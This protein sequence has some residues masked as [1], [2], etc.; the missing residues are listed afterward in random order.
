MVLTDQGKDDLDEDEHDHQHFEERGPGGLGLVEHRPRSALRR[1]LLHRSSP[2][3][4]ST[5]NENMPTLS[6]MLMR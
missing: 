1:W 2:N 3:D 5:C 4:T 6:P